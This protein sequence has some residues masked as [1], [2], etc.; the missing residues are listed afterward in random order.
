VKIRYDKKLSRA[1][2]LNWWCCK[3]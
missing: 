3:D 1:L 2:L